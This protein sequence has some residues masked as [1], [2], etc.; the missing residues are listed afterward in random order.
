MKSKV[1]RNYIKNRTR[2]MANIVIKKLKLQVQ[3]YSTVSHG[4]LRP[5][6]QCIYC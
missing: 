3:Q 4:F 2:L 6:F 1:M 5:T